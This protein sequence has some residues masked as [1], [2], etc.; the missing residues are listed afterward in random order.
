MLLTSKALR[1]LPSQ[2]ILNEVFEASNM[3]TMDS[4]PFEMLVHINSF[5]PDEKKSAYATISKTWQAVIEAQTSRS[6]VVQYSDVAEF[7]SALR[8]TA[9]RCALRRLEWTTT[10]S[11]TLIHGARRVRP[12]KQRKVELEEFSASMVALLGELAQWE[13]ECR[14]IESPGAHHQHPLQRL[15]QREHYMGGRCR[16][17]STGVRSPWSFTGGQSSCESTSLRC[18]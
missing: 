18:L 12:R 4:L 2:R 10:L 5:L 9:R 3:T 17:H 11:S 14:V 7:Q 8:T 1:Y 15:R 16:S 13:Q 6:L